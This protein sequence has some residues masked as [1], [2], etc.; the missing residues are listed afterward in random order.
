MNE[1]QEVAWLGWKAGFIVNPLS[2]L[3]WSGSHGRP[4]SVLIDIDGEVGQD[5]RKH[6]DERETNDS[7]DVSLWVERSVVGNGEKDTTNGVAKGIDQMSPL[8]RKGS[9][10]GGGRLDLVWII[11]EVTIRELDL[12]FVFNRLDQHRY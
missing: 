4:E 1:E 9:C 5:S 6:K 7:G 11:C 2:M 8:L 12:S 3:Q 10:L